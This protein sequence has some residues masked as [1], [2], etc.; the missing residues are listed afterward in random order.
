MLTRESTC[1][2]DLQAREESTRYESATLVLARKGQT[3][4]QAP[5][6]SEEAQSFFGLGVTLK[7]LG[8]RSQEQATTDPPPAAF[9][10]YQTLRQHQSPK[11]TRKRY[12]DMA[13]VAPKWATD[14]CPIEAS[15][16][17]DDA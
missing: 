1:P 10:S 9:L 12:D 17:E 15:S 7:L 3:H 2:L 4:K 13:S 11:E 8:K 6:D 5:H 14:E 16:F